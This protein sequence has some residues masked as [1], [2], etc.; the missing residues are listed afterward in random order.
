[1][2][3]ESYTDE[4]WWRTADPDEDYLDPPPALKSRKQMRQERKSSTTNRPVGGINRDTP[5]RRKVTATLREDEYLRDPE[6]DAVD[7]QPIVAKVEGGARPNDD[8]DNKNNN[9]VPESVG[10]SSSSDSEYDTEYEEG[11]RKAYQNRQPWMRDRD[12]ARKYA[13]TSHDLLCQYMLRINTSQLQRDSTAV[14]ALL[15]KLMLDDMLELLSE[16]RTQLDHVDVDLADGDMESRILEAAGRSTR[17]NLYW[18]RS[19]A[20]ELEEWINHAKTSFKELPVEME[21][22]LLDISDSILSLKL[23]IESTISLYSASASLAQSALVIDQTSGINKLTEL[24][25][26]F[27]P[28][29]F[30]TSIFSMQ[31]LELTSRPPKIWTWGVALCAVVLITYSIRTAIRSPSMRM[32]AL[33]CKATMLSRF[34]SGK[35]GDSARRF[36]TVGTRTVLKFVFFATSLLALVFFVLIAT[37]LIFLFFGFGLWIGGAGVALYF[38]ITRWPD[39]TVLGTC[40]ASLIVAACGLW[41]S[42][43]WIDE[44]FKG[45]EQ[46]TLWWAE[47]VKLLFP[48]K[49]LLDSVDDDDLAQEGVNTYARQALLLA[50]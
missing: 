9:N 23:R 10:I 19:T 32:M 11:L 29:S 39:A 14:P 34:T 4:E 31:V 8:D 24:A 47:R 30:I 2:E 44:M 15:M 18:L 37:F 21:T 43:L 6:H 5:S 22:G 48:E 45:F 20:I 28:M 50:T 25:F 33:H 16:I 7:K 40:F 49:W 1:M 46:V 42:C 36:N 13:R 26:F 38:I 27:V 17:L 41:V 12:Y 35:P 3:L